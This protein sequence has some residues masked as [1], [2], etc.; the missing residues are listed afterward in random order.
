MLSDLLCAIVVSV[1][2]R[3]CAI[4]VEWIVMLAN[5]PGKWVDHAAEP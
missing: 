2:Y 5:K 1:V 4:P 3:G